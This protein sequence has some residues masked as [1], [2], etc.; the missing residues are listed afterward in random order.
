MQPKK[1]INYKE[2]RITFGVKEPHLKMV[3]GQKVVHG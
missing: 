1:T 3:Y 2:I